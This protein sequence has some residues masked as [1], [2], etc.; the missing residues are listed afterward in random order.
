M[1]TDE[2]AE[3]DENLVEVQINVGTNSLSG[4]I[5]MSTRK[6]TGQIES[7]DPTSVATSHVPFHVL[8]FNKR[9]FSK[10][11]NKDINRVINN[12]VFVEEWGAH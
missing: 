1:L 2:Q 9:P 12:C 8:S 10:H 7:N 6:C 11:K 3:S 5:S 4:R